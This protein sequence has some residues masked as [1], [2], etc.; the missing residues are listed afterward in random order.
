MC[1]HIFQKLIKFIHQETHLPFQVFN[2]T[3]KNGNPVCPLPLW[4]YT[5]QSILSG[6]RWTSTQPKYSNYFT[7]KKHLSISRCL[8]YFFIPN[9]IH[10]FIGFMMIF[11]KKDKNFI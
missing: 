6:M 11:I 10:S 8:F 2:K 7:V 9:R 5:A 3:A 1:M 4:I